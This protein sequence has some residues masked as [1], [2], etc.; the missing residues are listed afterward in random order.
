MDQLESVISLNLTKVFFQPALKQILLRDS[1]CAQEI[2]IF[3]VVRQWAAINDDPAGVESLLGAVRWD[4][5]TQAELVETV[6]ESK[7]LQSDMILVRRYST[8]PRLYAIIVSLSGYFCFAAT[9]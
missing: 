4:L 9:G 3:S 1:I 6:R 7:L 2:D 5:L 8:L